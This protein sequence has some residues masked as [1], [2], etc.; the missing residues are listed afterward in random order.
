MDVQ[1]AKLDYQ[2]VEKVYAF[3]KGTLSNNNF[4]GDKLE[5]RE[6]PRTALWSIVTDYLIS[7]FKKER[8]RKPVF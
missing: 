4:E 7:F 5:I 3:N 1:T 2:P 8:K 6:V